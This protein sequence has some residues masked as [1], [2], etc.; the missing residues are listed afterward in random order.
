MEKQKREPRTGPE[1]FLPN[2]AI[3]LITP[4][5]ANVVVGLFVSLF[6]KFGSGSPASISWADA[7][8]AGSAATFILVAFGFVGLTLKG[9]KD[10]DLKDKKVAAQAAGF[11]IT[12]LALGICFRVWVWSR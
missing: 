10:L 12:M 6:F 1:G 3:G 2:F 5:I 11:V 7:I 9:L 8:L 4:L